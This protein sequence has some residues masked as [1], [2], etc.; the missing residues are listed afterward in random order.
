MVKSLLCLKVPIIS[1][2]NDTELAQ[3]ESTMD[4]IDKAILKEE[5]KEYIK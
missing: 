4:D 1:K 5:I 3:G 2:P